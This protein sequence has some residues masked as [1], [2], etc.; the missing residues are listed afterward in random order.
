[1]PMCEL[2][3]NAD[4]ASF[5]IRRQKDASARSGLS[6]LRSWN[7]RWVLYRTSMRVLAV[8]RMSFRHS[9]M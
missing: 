1:M 7:M 9:A 5:R 6:R 2:R 8:R 4:G 3:S